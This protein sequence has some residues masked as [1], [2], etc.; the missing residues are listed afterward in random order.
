MNMKEINS[1]GIF[2]TLERFILSLV[3]Y[4]KS[5]SI[6]GITLFMGL[7]VVIDGCTTLPERIPAAET[8]R[9]SLLLSNCS[10]LKARNHPVDILIY[11]ND[12]AGRLNTYQRIHGMNP[13]LLK[14]SSTAG[15]MLFTVLSN[16]GRE[17]Y[18]WLDICSRGS[19]GK[20]TV[21]LED[22]TRDELF[23][24]GEC[25]GAAGTGIPLTLSR[26]C[27]EIRLRHISCN[28]ISEAYSGRRI[29]SPKVYLI[30]VN[31][32]TP[33][34]GSLGE[35]AVRII[36]TGRLDMDAVNGFKE[37]DIICQELNRA[38][39]E[40]PYDAGV[41]L[42]CYSNLVNEES[43][44]T[45]LTR[46]VIEGTVSGKKYYWSVN[47]NM[48]GDGIEENCRYIYDICIRR[49]GTSDPD[50]PVELKN[51]EIIME[52]ERWKEKEEY[53]IRF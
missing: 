9:T 33:V 4:A 49:P 28:F 37:P 32:E 6:L 46:L 11:N 51:G 13:S 53:G 22:E 10:G 29:K 14:V 44:G 23:M 12:D 15:E 25:T 31:A 50:I 30:N 35:H 36:N 21:R 17:S 43:P 34:I 39:D 48:E 27:A 38:I 24:S 8:V 45:P 40:Q 3:G 47:I 18:D 41:S 52:V 7:P 20:M 19:L 5:L 2:S 26:K 42:L 16:S 1:R